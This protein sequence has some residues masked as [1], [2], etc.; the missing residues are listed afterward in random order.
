M[1][2]VVVR[3]QDAASSPLH[4]QNDL[5]MKFFNALGG[6]TQ[7]VRAD[8]PWEHAR[9]RGDHYANVHSSSA[10]RSDDA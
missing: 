10:T 3:Q 8:A 4:S 7:I 5:N 2:T 9:L 1:P 6:P